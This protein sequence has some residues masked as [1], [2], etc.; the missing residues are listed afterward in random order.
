MP[1]ISESQ[2]QAQYDFMSRVREINS[3]KGRLA[4]YIK[5][6]GCQQNEAD[7]E[8]L[9]GML[10]L[11][12]YDIEDDAENADIILINTCAVREHAE[13]KAMSIAGRFKLLK[14][15]ERD[16]IIGVFGCMVTQEG[17]SANLKEKYPYVDILF[18]TSEL[19][20][21][22]EILYTRLST[23]KRVFEPG[24]GRYSDI[25]EGLP[26]V[27]SDRY[28]AYISVMYGCDNFCTYCIVPHVRGRER[29]REREAVLA[30]VRKAV[31]EGAREITL[32]GQ[33]VNSYGHGLYEDYDFA[34]LLRDVCDIDGDFTVR[35]MT[36]HPKD[37]TDRLISVMAAEPKVSKA[38]H[39][40]LQS[41]S[42]RVLRAMNRVYKRDDY[43]ALVSRIR[44]AMPDIALTTDII[45]GFP[46]ETEEDFLDTV[47]IVKRV[48]Y[49]NIYSFIY[50]PRRG[51]PAAD[52]EQLPYEIKVDRY[53]RLI[54][55]QSEMELAFNRGLEGSTIEVLVEGRSKT[56]TDKLTGR[57]E[58]GKLV[59]FSGPDC[60]IG[61][62]IGVRITHA[63]TFALYG[64]L[65]D[66]SLNGSAL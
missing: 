29:S 42:D 56:D 17:V 7:S 65:P 36:S 5:T 41:G 52:M 43:L 30:D 26:S 24:K 11:M 55:V 53:Q 59:H 4:A 22:P 31:S 16:M 51:T 60:L 38:L 54:A 61:Q 32:L 12:G 19:W 33:N 23:G 27:R 63:E 35:F 48:K 28:R 66:T 18:G 6:F 9:A 25:A 10:A 14:A 47:D 58:R 46:G 2:I 40:P 3:H 50:S 13:S 45:V 57:T 20:R 62:R 64:E 21:M 39:L 37:M 1:R 8:E 49:D 34:D 15:K 44:A